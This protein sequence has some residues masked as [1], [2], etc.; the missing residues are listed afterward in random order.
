[1]KKFASTL[2]KRQ[3]AAKAVQAA[4]RLSRPRVVGMIR[5][6]FGFVNG[7]IG[8]G[9]LTMP[10]TLRTMGY[11]VGIAGTVFMGVLAAITCLMLTRVALAE[12][13]RT[14]DAVVRNV[15]GPFWHK[16]YE[17]MVVFSS[18][19]VL[20]A[21]LILCGDFLQ[22]LS[23]QLAG[24]ALHRAIAVSA[25]AVFIVLPLALLRFVSSLS[26]TAYL[27]AA[28]I[29]V[30]VITVVVKAGQNGVIA[31]SA[32]PLHHDALDVFRGLSLLVLSYSSQ[33]LVLP[34]FQELRDRTVPRAKILINI[35]TTI[36]TIVYLA[37]G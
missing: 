25:C 8:T 29:T 5:S 16:T 15:L 18:I 31:P 37:I 19:G 30:L 10:I 3:R 28:F 35:N 27:S 33:T 24:Y 36:V 11:G 22:A 7:C 12:N 34:V 1:M 13:L 21:I 32:E 17:F 9:A 2:A 4:V 20:I 6:V 26:F 14:Y 23:V